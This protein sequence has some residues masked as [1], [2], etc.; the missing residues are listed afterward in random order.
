MAIR[1]DAVG[2]AWDGR[3]CIRARSSRPPAGLR[4]DSA[5]AWRGVAS[6]LNIARAVP[7]VSFGPCTTVLGRLMCEI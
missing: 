4:F 2:T 3:H 5:V 7:F 6:D 1:T